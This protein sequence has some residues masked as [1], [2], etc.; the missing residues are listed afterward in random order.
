MRGIYLGAGS[1]GWLEPQVEIVLRLDLSFTAAAFL[2]TGLPS[3]Q[4]EEELEGGERL[5]STHESSKQVAWLGHQ[6]HSDGE[7]ATS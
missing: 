1:C 4:L 7:L 3:S 2:Q 6:T 5:G